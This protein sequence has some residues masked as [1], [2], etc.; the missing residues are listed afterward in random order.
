VTPESLAAVLGVPTRARGR[1]DPASD[2][3]PPAIVDAAAIERL[4][5]LGGSDA[6]FVGGLLEIFAR[7]SP[8]RIAA[9]R[10]ALERGDAAALRFEAHRI[11]GSCRYVG[12]V[13][14]ART[15]GAL[16]REARA[17]HISGI[18]PILDRLHAE[19]AATLSA[20]EGTLE[21]TRRSS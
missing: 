12:A 19:V 14:M 3:D 20:L 8:R 17:G 4:Q 21:R 7:E 15:A 9:M 18:P 16:E 5:R 13:A 2:P 11:A 10:A 6:A 1:Q